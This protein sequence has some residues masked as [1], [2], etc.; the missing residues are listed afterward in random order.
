MF[1]ANK[2]HNQN[3]YRRVCTI[4][5]A[6]NA[7]IYNAKGYK[8]MTDQKLR[9]LYFSKSNFVMVDNL[10]LTDFQAIRLQEPQNQNQVVAN[11]APV[12][13]NRG[14]RQNYFN[15]NDT[16]NTSSQEILIQPHSNLPQGPPPNMCYQNNLNH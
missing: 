6:D 12:D 1:C 11:Y 7:Q 3:L 10:N 15:M 8:W 16:R 2:K 13:Q 5:N 9:A 4:L 14:D